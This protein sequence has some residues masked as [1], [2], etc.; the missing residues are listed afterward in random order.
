[1][2][3]LFAGPEDDPEV[4]MSAALDGLPHPHGILVAVGDVTTKTLLD[5]GHI[6]DI[7]LIDG[8]TKRTE[9]DESLKVDPQRFQRQ[10]AAVNPA[11]VLTPS[12]NQA[13]EQALHSEQTVVIEVDGEEDLAPLQIH[14]HAPLGTIVMYGQPKTG[15]VVQVTTMSVKQR[16]RHLLSMFE[17][18]K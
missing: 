11:G 12:L 2:G 17:V 16:C 1:M 14:C 10:I 18:E 13:I 15:V 8:Q 9:L 7:A 6:P 4:G 3:E 5:M